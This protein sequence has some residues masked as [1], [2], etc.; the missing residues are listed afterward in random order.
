MINSGGADPAR[1]SG[2]DKQRI[3]I[4]HGEKDEIVPVHRSEEI[5]EA[6]MKSREQEPRVQTEGDWVKAADDADTIRFWKHSKSGHVPSFDY[7][8]AL[9]WVLHRQ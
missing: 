4:I 5:F 2:L 7:Q 8:T 6:L 3:W 1:T 9:D